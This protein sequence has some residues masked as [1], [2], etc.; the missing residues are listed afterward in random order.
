MPTAHALLSASASKRWSCCPPSA[1]LHAK[2]EQ[3]VGPTTSAYAEEGTLAHS[4]AELKLRKEIG[5]LNQFSYDE[6]HKALGSIPPEMEGYTDYYADEV[7]A[8]YYEACKT[9]PDAQLMVEVQVDLGPWV[10][11]GFGTSDAVIVSDNI[12]DVIDL[13][14]G[15]GV[16]V[17]AEDNSQLRLYALGTYNLL[18]ALYSFD[19]VRTTIIQPRVEDGVSSELMDLVDLRTWGQWIKGRADLAWQGQGEFSAGD[20]C[21]WCAARP[22]CKER[23]RHA[24]DITRYGFDS[25]DVISEDELPG[26]LR[27]ADVAIEWLKDVQAYA[28]ARAKDGVDIR[29]YKLVRGRKPGRKWGDEDEARNILAHAGYTEDQYCEPRVFTSPSKLEKAIGKKAFTALVADK[30]FQGEGSLTLVPESDKRPAVNSADVE[31][32]DMKE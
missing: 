24:M 7:M 16:K 10:K 4:L 12:L 8:R 5:E 11:E 6:Q 30:T 21:R 9:C 15:A 26:I 19:Q 22:L 27:C 31:F 17:H 32:A 28:L 25:P 20:H 13:K 2:I 1:R 18:G 23:A 3:R 14:Y 29:G